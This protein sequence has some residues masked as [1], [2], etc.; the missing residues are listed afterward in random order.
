MATAPK[1]LSDGEVMDAGRGRGETLVHSTLRIEA[2]QKLRS[3]RVLNGGCKWIG[4][5]G[6]LEFSGPFCAEW[7]G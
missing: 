4:S 3:D 5:Q 2:V 1:A 6:F 7:S